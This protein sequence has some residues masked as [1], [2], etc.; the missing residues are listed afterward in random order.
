MLFG[1]KKRQKHVSQLDLCEQ[2]LLFRISLSL[3]SK[4]GIGTII[5]IFSRAYTQAHLKLLLCT[6]KSLIITDS[7]RKSFRDKFEHYQDWQEEHLF[8][9][10]AQYEVCQLACILA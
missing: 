1:S 2:E 6:G 4:R 9:E 10:K 8:L 5:H 7:V 3:S